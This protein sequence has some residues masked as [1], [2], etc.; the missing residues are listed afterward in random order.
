MSI[1]HF[2]NFG[3]LYRAAF[4][5]SDPEIKQIL[6]VDV[7]RAL[8]RWAVSQAAEAPRA[9]KIGPTSATTTASNQHAAA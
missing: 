3:D 8:D 4:A 1:H 6:L 7:K 2:E 9:A 5:E